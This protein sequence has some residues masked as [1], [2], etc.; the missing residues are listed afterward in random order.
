MSTSHQPPNEPLPEGVT[1]REHTYDGIQEYDQRLPNWW[2]FTFYGAILITLI[3]W[4]SWY[5]ADVMRTDEASLEHAMQQI[6]AERL[7]SVGKLTDDAFWAMSK[8]QQL[9]AEGKAVYTTN[10][11]VC[12]LPNLRGKEQ[13][14]IGESLANNTWLYGAT[15]MDIYKVVMDGSPNKA[16]G[17]Q[18]W[19]GV[20]GP[21]KVSRVVAYVLSHHQADAQKQA[22]LSSQ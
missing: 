11:V 4:F 10:C 12:H 17:M 3:Y 16:S 9:L 2:L 1:L 13:G 7:K 20:L 5:D 15:P 19:S 8:N 22:T 21:E 6:E 14:G 18:S